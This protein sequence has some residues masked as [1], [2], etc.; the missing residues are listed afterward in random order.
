MGA[1][2][3]S[4]E[5]FVN[6]NLVNIGKRLQDN[7]DV[8][9][10]ITGGDGLPVEGGATL[11]DRTEAGKLARE[12][13]D[14]LGHD[15]AQVEAELERMSARTGELEKFRDRMTAIR[16]DVD[17]VDLSSVGAI[18][19]LEEARYHIFTASGRA[20]TFFAA[21]G[22]G[23]SSD[24]REFEH[25]PWG[26]IFREAFPLMLALILAALIVGTAVFLALH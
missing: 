4:R 15:L 22:G 8:L 26:E 20:H 1:R 17:A 25:K 2:I 19:K 18:R 7:Y 6:D 12:L 9:N 5:G 10:N 13:G 16:A 14:R 24:R 11:A 3:T 23:A 21:S